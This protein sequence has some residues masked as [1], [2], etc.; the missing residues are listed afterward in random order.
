[1]QSGECGLK[2]RRMQ[3]WPNRDVEQLAWNENTVVAM[4]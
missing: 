3:R 4:K 2:L 1:M